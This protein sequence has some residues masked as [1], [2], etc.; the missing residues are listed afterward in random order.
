YQRGTDGGLTNQGWKDSVDSIFHED[1]RLARGPIALVEV[2]GYVYAAWRAMAAMAERLGCESPKSWEA[3]AEAMRLRV[4]RRFW[5]IDRD[6]Y[7]LAIDGDGELCRPMSSNPGHLLFA[8]LPAPERAR[9]TIRRLLSTRFD[10]GWGLRTLATGA[11]RYNPMSY[12]NG[13][14]WPHD[15]A[16][17]AAGMARYGER[18][19]PT[20]ILHDLFDVA[21]AFDM[22]MPELLCGFPREAEAPPI[23]YPSA[24]MPQAWAAGSTFMLLQACL[25]LS[26]DAARM[27]VRIVRPAL[28]EGVDQLSIR[29]LAV[30]EARI[31]LTFQRLG[32]RLAAVP[33]PATGGSISVIIEG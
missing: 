14:V 6:F 3:R 7:G 26:I 28:P 10:S 30:G 24:C 17:I 19:G 29:G 22:R 11:A 20:K 12:H 23:A 2:Q 5:M 33:A 1:G 16:L 21:K 18:E 9:K 15:T 13:S 32:G 8:G 31:D 25:G 4:E 27:E